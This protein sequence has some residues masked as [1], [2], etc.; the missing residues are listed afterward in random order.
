MIEPSTIPVQSNSPNFEKWKKQMTLAKRIGMRAAYEEAW[1]KP[2]VI[3]YKD[4][5]W[6]VAR[7]NDMDRQALRSGCAVMNQDGNGF[8]YFAISNAQMYNT[9][10]K[11]KAVEDYHKQAAWNNLAGWGEILEKE[12]G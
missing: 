10:C 9:L 7:L 2:L 1:D 8:W 5:D 12:Q 6:C 4:L 11:Q 3:A